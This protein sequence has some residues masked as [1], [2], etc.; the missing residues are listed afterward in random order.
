MVAGRGR[1]LRP[2]GTWRSRPWIV[3]LYIMCRDISTVGNLY[4]SYNILE[5]SGGALL[6][7]SSIAV[8]DIAH[9]TIVSIV[10]SAIRTYSRA[11]CN[12]MHRS[13]YDVSST[14]MSPVIR[15]IRIEG[16]IRWN[17]NLSNSTKSIDVKKSDSLFTFIEYQVF[18]IIC[19]LYTESFIII[20]IYS[21]YDNHLF[22]CN[23]LW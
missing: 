19:T 10:S 17:S 13:I 8:S 3:E 9:V 14:Y 23:Q 18:V 20:Y 16:E 11:S 5:R 7:I 22:K 4:R 21:W 1:G 6:G 12:T 2:G 15:Y